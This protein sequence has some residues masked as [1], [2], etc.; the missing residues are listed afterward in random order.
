MS[1]PQHT[2]AIARFH[3]FNSGERAAAISTFLFALLSTLVLSIVLLSV[4]WVVSC[5]VFKRTSYQNL[6]LKAFFFRSQLGQYASCLLFSHWIRAVSGLI[7]IKWINNGEVKAGSACI[8]QGALR[9]IGQFGTFFFVVT[10]GIHTFNTLVLRNRPPQWLG[11]VI[12]IIACVSSLLIGLAPM[13]MSSHVSGPLYSID[14]F[15]CTISKSYPVPHMLLHFLP[16]FLASLLSVTV[17]SLIFLMLR[18][19]LVINGGLRIH[20]DPERRLRVHNGTFEEYQ[21]FVYSVAR[22]MLWLPITFVLISFPSSIAQLMDISGINVPPGALA[23]SY[24]LEYSEGV[25]NV[26]ILFNVLRALSTAVKSTAS[27]D[28]EKGSFEGPPISRPKHDWIPQSSFA[29]T[30]METGSVTRS[31]P[32]A[33]PP[34]SIFHGRTSRSSLAKSLFQGR[35]TGNSDSSVRLLTP[36]PP[37]RNDSPIPNLELRGSSSSSPLLRRILSPSNVLNTGP[38]V[39]AEGV[40]KPKQ[41]AQQL[42]LSTSDLPAFI[43]DSNH[44]GLTPSPRGKRARISRDLNPTSESPTV[45]ASLSTAAPFLEVTLR[46]PPTS[47]TAEVGGSVISMYFSRDSTVASELPPFPAAAVQRDSSVDLP[48]A[49]PPED[50]GLRPKA[51]LSIGAVGGRQRPARP[52]V[53]H[54]QRPPVRLVSPDDSTDASRYSDTEPDSPPSPEVRA[55][56]HPTQPLRVGK[57]TIV[58]APSRAV[59][60]R[61]LTSERSQKPGDRPGSRAL[62]VPPGSPKHHARTASVLSHASSHALVGGHSYSASLSSHHEYL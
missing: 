60:E 24:I 62:P 42:S 14:S 58:N 4:I 51:A 31:A 59:P 53:P 17:Y 9:Q 7:D 52:R 36:D 22:T 48:V 49:P 11:I 39:P 15:T 8:A 10:M 55:A 33:Y 50:V 45:S 12:I 5:T 25:I 3:A 34:G 19:T 32:P 47:P 41:I 2:A 29:S 6:S 38:A 26:F 16:L 21:R 46:S 37:S 54:P 13:S 61:S 1:V 56:L 44:S 57:T 27:T 20:L 43:H 30:K 35:K 23:F 28:S 40:Q 18:G